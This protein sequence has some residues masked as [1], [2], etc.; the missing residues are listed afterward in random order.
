MEALN[1]RKDKE[2]YMNILS[3]GDTGSYAELSSKDNPDMLVIS[4]NPRIE[5]MLERAS[6]IKGEP[7]SKG[8]I[9]RI[10]NNSPV[11][12]PPKLIP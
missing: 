10:R 6:Q 9:D 8:E 7:L 4:Y 12:F 2:S 5:A 11:T 1:S 3:V